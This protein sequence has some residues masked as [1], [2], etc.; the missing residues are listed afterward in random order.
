[1]SVLYRINY[2]LFILIEILNFFCINIVVE[3]VPRCAWTSNSFVLTMFLV[4][5]YWLIE[6]Q[7]KFT[8]KS[9]NAMVLTYDLLIYS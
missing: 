1:M 7:S 5:N 8:N 3:R 9:R 4:P 6:N 2:Q